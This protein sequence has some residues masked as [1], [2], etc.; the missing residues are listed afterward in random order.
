MRIARLRRRLAGW[1]V[2]R[3][4]TVTCNSD[5]IGTFTD[6]DIL[7]TVHAVAASTAQAGSGH[8]YHVLL[9]PFQDVC[10]SGVGCA[11]TTI[12][13]YHGSADFFDIGHVVYSVEPDQISFNCAIPAPTPNGVR[14]DSLYNVLSHELFGIVT[15]PDFNAWTNTANLSL[16][17][18]EI[19]DECEFIDASFSFDVPTFKIGKK[20]YAVQREYDNRQH[21]CATKPD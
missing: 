6:F 13:A 1:T 12:C 17:G 16:P 18:Q 15:D 7:A 14:A 3:S 4:A 10:A 11:S 8:L 2:G 5:F 19:G 20:L 21:T 9:P